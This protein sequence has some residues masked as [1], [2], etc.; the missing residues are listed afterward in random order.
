M[1]NHFTINSKGELSGFNA[2]PSSTIEQLVLPQV[3]GGVGIEEVA[4]SAFYNLHIKKLVIPGN[5]KR[6]RARAFRRCD[7]EEL[8]VSE[9]GA[10]LAFDY[11]S[12]S[13]NSL[14]R[15][16]LPERVWYIGKSAFAYNQILEEVNVEGLRTVYSYC[17]EGCYNLKSFHSEADKTTIMSNAIP[18]G[19]NIKITHG[20]DSVV[21]IDD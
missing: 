5:Y 19:V 6:I 3:I 13:Y 16:Y 10:E 1:T 11:Q 17:F 21:I 15:L 8:V 4:S 9:D 18:E 7:I 2:V 14:A 12:I 20:M